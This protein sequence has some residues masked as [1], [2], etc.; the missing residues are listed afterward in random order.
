[1]GLYFID[2][3]HPSSSTQHKWILTATD[4]F[5]KW[6]EEIPTKKAI[7]S[8]IIQFI[9]SNIL[10]RFGFPHKIITDNVVAFKS[11]RMVDL[12]AKYHIV[13]GHSPSYHPQGNGLVESS[14]KSL[15]NII[16][17][18]LEELDSETNDI[19]RRINQTIHLQ[20]T[21][22]E[23]LQNTSK[24][25]E[26]IKK[27]YDHKTKEDNFNLGDVVLRWDAR[28]EEKGKHGKFENLSK[29]LYRIYAFRGKYAFLLE[30]MDGRDYS[31][32]VTNGR[33]LEHY[34]V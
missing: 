27:I 20:Q 14:N 2:K 29:G 33:L 19:Q 28:N 32:G 10:S 25:Q 26:K 5:T 16:K 31:G 7:D 21:M 9:E 24:L 34:Y 8:V 12:C 30:E 17:K 22:E 23:V 4:Y 1:M 11:E 3:I 18:L 6:I 13:L 15:V